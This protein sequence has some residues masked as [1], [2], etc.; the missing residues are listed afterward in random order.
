MP[1]VD[2]PYE[3]LPD[4]VK[5]NLSEEQWREAQRGVILEGVKIPES[6]IYLNLKNGQQL[7]YEA[8]MRANAPLLPVHDLAG[9]RGADSSQF[10]SSPPGAHGVP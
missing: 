4:V 2:I 10:H 5:D 3:Q 6:T 9:G 7:P 8:G 1:Q